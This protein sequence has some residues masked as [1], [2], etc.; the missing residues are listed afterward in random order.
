MTCSVFLHISLRSVREVR[1]SF[2]FPSYLSLPFCFFL[3]LS[4]TSSFSLPLSFSFLSFPFSF[5]LALLS[6]FL[7][8]P[9]AIRTS[10]NIHVTTEGE[11]TTSLPSKSSAVPLFAVPGC[12]F[13]SFS[14][15]PS[16][17]QSLSLFLPL[18][19]RLVSRSIRCL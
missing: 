16:P 13:L 11:K 14:F 7:S 19:P 9:F 8:P 2:S 10:R 1:L 5:A 4:P 15:P 6:L 17:S 3:S 18:L 12:P